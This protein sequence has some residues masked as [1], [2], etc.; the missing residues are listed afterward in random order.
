MQAI[1]QIPLSIKL[2]LKLVHRII[3]NASEIFFAKLNLTVK[4]AV[5][6]H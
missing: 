1:L 6:E 3:M 2:D 4:L 5:T